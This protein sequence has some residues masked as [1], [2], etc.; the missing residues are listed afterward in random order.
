MAKK[1]QLRAEQ[2][3]VIYNAKQ[4]LLLRKFRS[5]AAEIME[6][7]EA[8]GIKTIIY[9]S[10]A[11]GDISPKSDIDVFISDP[12]ASFLIENILENRGLAI[13]KRTIIQATPSYAIKGYIE[14]DELR[15]VSFPLAKMRPTEREFYRFGGELSYAQVK[16][17]DRVLGIDKR[18]MLIVPTPHGHVEGS[19]IG[20]E[21]VVAKLLNVSVNIVLDRV[22]ALTRRDKVGRTGVFLK[23]ELAP[24]ESFESSLNELATTNPAIRRRLRTSAHA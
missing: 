17:E 7:F 18:L 16:H 21:E 4:W 9:G 1:P 11:R 19:V 20:Q 14:I 3:E 8:K 22:R 23:R 10:I 24:E 2:V 6:V 13:Q 12:P 15:S 5:L